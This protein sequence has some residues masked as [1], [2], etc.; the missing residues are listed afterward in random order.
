MVNRMNVHD[1][2]Q[3]AAKLARPTLVKPS[4]MRASMEQSQAAKSS[5]RAERVERVER[6]ENL[7]AS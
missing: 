4:S 6:V 2:I 3:P 5:E 7:L 1:M